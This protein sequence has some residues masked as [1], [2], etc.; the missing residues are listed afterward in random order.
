MQK[1]NTDSAK[2]GKSAE[3]GLTMV[4]SVPTP[5]SSITPITLNDCI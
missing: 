1:T 3:N 5:G 4:R 2:V